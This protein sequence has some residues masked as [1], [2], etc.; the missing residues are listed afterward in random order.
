[1]LRCEATP[2]PKVMPYP[3]KSFDYLTKNGMIR[4]NKDGMVSTKDFMV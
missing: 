3:E 2:L 1:M 4:K